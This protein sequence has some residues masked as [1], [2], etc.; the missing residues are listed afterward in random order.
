MPRI[1]HI[2]FLMFYVASCYAIGQERTSFVA[3]N[4]RLSGSHDCQ[5]ALRSRTAE[6]NPGWPN[7]RE[8]KPKPITAI[9]MVPQQ[10][11]SLRPH[12]NGYALSPQLSSL[13]PQYTLQRALDRAPPLLI[14]R[15]K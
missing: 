4:L 13:K 10:F 2:L 6:L 7:Y 1:F 14:R 9:E 8:A 5:D 15:S 3:S 12:V 11:V